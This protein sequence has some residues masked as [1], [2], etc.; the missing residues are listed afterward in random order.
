MHN[1]CK[2]SNVIKEVLSKELIVKL[3][4]EN[5]SKKVEAII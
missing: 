1:Y 5:Y 2:I 4:K 3:T